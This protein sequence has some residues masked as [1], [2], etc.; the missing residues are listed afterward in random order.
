MDNNESY[1][2]GL[3]ITDGCLSLESRN[4]GRISLEVNIRDKDIIDKL[5]NVIPNSKILTRSRKSKLIL[6]VTKLNHFIE[7]GQSDTDTLWVTIHCGCRNLGMKILAYWKKQLNQTR[8]NKAALKEAEKEVREKYRKEPRKIKDEIKKLQHDE[9]Y[10]IPPSKYLK[11]EDMRGYMADVMFAQAYA[12]Y[13]RKT[14]ADRIQQKVFGFS[15]SIEAIESVHNYIDP[16]DE[17]IRKGAISS[18]SGQKVVIPL[19]MARGV[20][21]CEG[22]GNPDWNNSAPHGAGRRLS[23]G[24]ARENI[25]LEEFK[26][27]MGNVFSTSICNAC[28]DESPSAYKDPDTI[29]PLIE[30]KTV[31]ILSIITP[32][33]SI[34][35]GT[36][37]GS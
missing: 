31:N 24:K 18:Y 26:E 15:G 8:V 19:N 10:V 28:L 12:E 25:T 3:L 11:D 4:R 14:I 2:Y 6:S 13:N 37:E 16:T 34:K 23:R 32:L 30:G 36:E 7:V 17:I 1:I 21:I 5:Y 33:I 27:S 20:L 35:A 22:L 9:R 29:I